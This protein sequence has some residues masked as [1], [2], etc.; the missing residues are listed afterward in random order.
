MILKKQTKN[1]RLLF[2]FLTTE[3][4]RNLIKS[5]ITYYHCKQLK[6]KCIVNQLNKDMGL[7]TFKL[8][9]STNKIVN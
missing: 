2:V 8:S 9:K 7:S 5:Y 1:T 3:P 6:C 4:T